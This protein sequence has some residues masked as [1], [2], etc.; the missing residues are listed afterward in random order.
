MA[1]PECGGWAD[2]VGAGG[3][4]CSAAASM[5]GSLHTRPGTGGERNSITPHTRRQC[6]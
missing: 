4:E 3:R 5:E 6:I 1:L 2:T